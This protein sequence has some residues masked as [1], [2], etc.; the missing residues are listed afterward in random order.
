MH[1]LVPS[2]EVFGGTAAST[3]WPP[4]GGWPRRITS[5]E[6]D[7]SINSPER[8]LQMARCLADA[9]KAGGSA[10]PRSREY[11]ENLARSS[12]SP[13]FRPLESPL[14]AISVM[15]GCPVVMLGA[16]NYLGLT[17]D[18]RV[19]RA[20]TE[21]I[22]RYGTGC[23]GSR[24]MNGTLRLHL[25]LEERLACFLGKEAALVFSAGFL[26]NQGV[27]SALS[28]RDTVFISDKLN[29]ASICE[30]LRGSEAQCVRFKHNDAD[31]LRRKLVDL[32]PESLKWVVVEGVHS[33]MGDICPLPDLTAVAKELG[34]RIILDDAHGT[35]VLGAGGQGSA[36]SF[37]LVDE[38]DLITGT[39][40]K[41]F[42]SYG[43]FVAGD[44]QTIELLRY[45]SRQFIFTASL[46]PAN[47]AT[48]LKVLDILER[49]PEIVG[50]LRR[51]TLDLAARLQASG[52]CRSTPQ[53]AII[54][55]VVGR[56]DLAWMAW[57]LL[58][59]LGVYTNAAFPPGVPPG[60]ALLRISMMASLKEAAI[61]YAADAITATFSMLRAWPC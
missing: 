46:P 14:E 31:H 17:T 6:D 33:M 39:F 2:S 42:A 51:N 58:Y 7:T 60:Q 16:N 1:Q 56:N 34:A 61:A 44:R 32:P 12:C 27:L 13:F 54:P 40:S 53:A 47:V 10:D 48:V 25:E 49:E 52:L 41:T 43:G 50:R 26:A 35:G 30:G 45:G 59:E 36:S 18:P 20:A 57:R 28:T 11:L 5:R 38:V 29:H 37:G 55:L 3:P 22:Q 4:L 15:D 23:T 21:A 24:L 8:Q 9:E 19:V